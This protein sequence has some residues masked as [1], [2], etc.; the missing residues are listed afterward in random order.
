[1][2]IIISL[3]LLCFLAAC[4]LLSVKDDA[5]YL[6]VLHTNDNHG[7]FWH[8]ENGE[9]G[10]AARK[11]L[12]D[13]LRNDALEQGHSVILL[14]GGD[15][16]TGVPESDLQV[17][18]PDF[19]GMSIIG[20]DAMA[21]GNH[22]FDNP[23]SVL[24]KQIK[25]SNFPLLSANII[26]KETNKPAYQAYTILEKGQLKIA[27]IGLTTVDTAKIANPQYIGHLDF[28]TPAVATQPL[29]DM[30][31]ST[32][33]PDVVVAVTHM[34]HYHDAKHG[35][36]APGDVT[37]A[38]D[39]SPNSLDMIIGGHSQEP[40][41]VDET[42][43]Q[44]PS[45]SPGKACWPDRQNGTWI[46]QAHEWGKYVGKAVFKIENGIKELL[47]YELVPVNLKD[48][49]GNFITNEI[50]KDTS[51]Y[52]F[53]LPYQEKGAEKLAGAVGNVDDFLDG[54]RDTVRFT[55]SKLA[56]LI[57]NAQTEAVGADFG[58]IS[59]GGIRASIEK[60]DVNYK[61]ILKVHPF[62]NRVAYIDWQG[63]EL[64]DYI[65]V[66]GSF[67]ADA[68]A[69]LQYHKIDFSIENGLANIKTINGKP[70]DI[71]GIYRMSIN[72][73]NAAGGDGYPIITEKESYQNTDSTDAQV[74]RAYIEKYSPIKTG[75]L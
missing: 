2:R 68:G 47:S 18:E 19:K 10:M 62:R 74:L 70:F 55:Q 36:N 53:L 63:P 3:F 67:P 72:S 52:N 59:G 32:Y 50:T 29:V 28:I 11:T 27:V 15:I 35:I 33:Q 13:Q 40:I 48:E 4:Q 44:D 46:M 12:I 45:F 56:D 16:N 71:N 5:Q 6:T 60:G 41:C 75:N 65:S 34:G 69:Y 49:Q 38:R 61:D 1:M 64:V 14:S 7:R 66:V 9:Y 23:L 17:A 24:D 39:L 26:D 42:G 58:I 43:K 51:L 37:L 20:Y 31:K 54:R 57:I 73:Y 22:E 30:I 21:I 8:N 25:W